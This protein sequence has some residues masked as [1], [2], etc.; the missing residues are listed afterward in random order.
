MAV[1]YSGC[2]VEDKQVFED[3]QTLLKLLKTP[4]IQ[5]CAYHFATALMQPRLMDHQAA[6]KAILLRNL[7]L[8]KSNTG[9]KELKVYL[10]AL[11]TL[12][13]TQPVTGRVVDLELDATRVEIIPLQNK[14]FQ[15]SLNIHF[16]SKLKSVY[17]I[18]SE[19][20]EML[21][22]SAWTLDDYLKRNPLLDFFEKGVVH[23]VQA[24]T[25]IEK[26]KVGYWNHNDYYISPGGWVIGLLKQSIIAEVA[27][28]F[29]E[30]LAQWFATQ[31]LP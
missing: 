21:Y 7:Q 18:G 1:Q 27:P 11:S 19:K 22:R 24:N 15:T 8:L 31:V 23:V 9:S 26:P 16:P 14:V 13:N 25:S 20:Q 3:K 28:S 17:F 6:Q 12:I 29:N 2:V 10:T 4:N 30:D 5:P